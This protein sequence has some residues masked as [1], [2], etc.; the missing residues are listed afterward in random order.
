MSWMEALLSLQ[1]L[2]EVSHGAPSR[3]SVYA[4]KDLED[5]AATAAIAAITREH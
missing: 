2:A 5:A 1:V 4:A 3:A